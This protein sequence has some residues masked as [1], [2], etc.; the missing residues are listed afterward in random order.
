MTS[1]PIATQPDAGSADRRLPLS[2]MTHV[3]LESIECVH[4]ELVRFS[5]QRLAR[6]AELQRD[7]V[8]ARTPSDAY[9]AMSRFIEDARGDYLAEALTFASVTTRSNVRALRLADERIR[10][11]L[12]E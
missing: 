12:P 6:D 7:L 3:V 9:G 5:A 11:M 10:P 1:K 2:A 4:W 8:S